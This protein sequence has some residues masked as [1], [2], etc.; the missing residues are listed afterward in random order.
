MQPATLTAHGNIAEMAAERGE[1]AIAALAVMRADAHQMGGVA[2]APHHLRQRGLLEPGIAVVEQ[3]LGGL[4]RI[5]ERGRH[6]HVSEPQAGAQ[7]LREGPEIDG[8]IRRHAGDR[9]Q[10]RSFIA[11]VAVVIVFEDVAPAAPGPGDGLVAAGERQRVTG[12]ILVRWGE[13]E[14]RR[15]PVRQGFRDQPVAHRPGRR[16]FRR[17]PLRRRG[18]RPDSTVS[19]PPRWTSARETAGR[20]R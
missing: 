11:E 10:R 9:L 17:R 5:D 14:Q 16:R 4:R 15:R 18:S 20:R 12:W 6:D 13:V 8:A 3:R 7:R 1:Q 2:A 19:R